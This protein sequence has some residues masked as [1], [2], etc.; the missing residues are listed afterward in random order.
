MSLRSWVE[1]ELWD[2]EYF[3]PHRLSEGVEIFRCGL[4]F[5]LIASLIDGCRGEP[6][7]V[8][9]SDETYTDALFRALRGLVRQYG[10]SWF[11]ITDPDNAL[12]VFEWE[13]EIDS[14]YVTSL[15]LFNSSP[16]DEFEKNPA[17]EGGNSSLCIGFHDREGIVVIEYGCILKITLYGTT[18]RMAAM[19]S[20]LGL[21][22]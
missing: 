3:A 20:G 10:A 14:G 13:R 22:R 7:W 15:P 17:Q 1:S 6:Q 21:S 16:L 8:R 5:P 19:L 9:G 4:S 2:E 18:E 12:S 11:Y